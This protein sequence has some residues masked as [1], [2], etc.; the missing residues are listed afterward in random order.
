MK[1]KFT[2]AILGLLTLTIKALLIFIIIGSLD[3]V[4]EI[5]FNHKA[6][7]DTFNLKSFFYSFIAVSALDSI[8]YN[9][10]Y[11]EVKDVQ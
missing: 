6:F 9:T 8:N 1:I 3:F 10:K 4:F 11:W 7:E 5:I 2:Y